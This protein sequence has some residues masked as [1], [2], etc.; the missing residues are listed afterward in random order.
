MMD[1]FHITDAPTTNGYIHVRQDICSLER[2][3]IFLAYIVYGVGG[4]Q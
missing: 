1:T 4:K 3:C 2:K